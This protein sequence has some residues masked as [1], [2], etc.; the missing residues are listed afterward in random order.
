[1]QQIIDAGQRILDPEFFL[2]DSLGIFR[3]QTTNPV[4]WR[5]SGQEALF[6]RLLLGHGQFAGPAR[7]GFGADRLQTMIPVQVDPL[8]HKPPAAGQD[9][10]DR[11]ST[12]AFQGQQDGSIA[13]SLLGIALL[14]TSLTQLLDIVRMMGLDLHLTVPP[15]SLRVCQKPAS[16]ATL[17]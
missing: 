15:V 13:V 1:M 6:E 4:G 9:L 7:L 8:L 3:P 5:G 11:W 17:F 2:E 12:V 10:C 16:R 14:V